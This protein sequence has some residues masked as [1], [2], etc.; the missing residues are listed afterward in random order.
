[1]D[2]LA[3]PT[4]TPVSPFA[5]RQAILVLAMSVPVAT[6]AA[7]GLAAHAGAER[8]VAA[9]GLA[10]CLLTLGSVAVLRGL[11]LSAY[12]HRRL[13][14][15]NV[16]TLVRGAAIAALAGLLAVPDAL[17]ALGYPLAGM[18][19]V[20]LALDGVDGWA[21]RRAGLASSFG[22]RLDVETDV[23]FALVMAGLAI[24]MGK[25]GMWFL[26][27]G[28]MRP[29]FMLAGPVWPWLTAP[30]TPSQSRR[31]VAGVQ[32]GGQV[33]LLLPVLVAPV[34]HW[35]G[36]LILGVVVVSFT[37]DILV[38]RATSREAA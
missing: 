10:A 19:A 34:S 33:A 12:P 1:M 3:P 21:A 36:A 17:G 25:V 14:A 8:A 15:C 37:R 11:H 32:M 28:L 18:A 24:A 20:I 27:L 5:Q 22:A 9:A 30:L 35:L 16:V 29:A 38:L 4:A 7:F 23:V 31:F 26:A 2:T 6:A 13:G